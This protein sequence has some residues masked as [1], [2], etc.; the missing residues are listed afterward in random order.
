MKQTTNHRIDSLVTI[1]L[2]T[3]LRETVNRI[4]DDVQQEEDFEREDVIKY[5]ERRLRRMRGA[6]D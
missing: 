1:S 3:E 2:L 4:V 5:L 6:H